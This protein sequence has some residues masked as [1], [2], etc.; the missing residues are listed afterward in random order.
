MKNTKN[1]KINVAKNTEVKGKVGRPALAVTLPAS[2]AFT[3][4]QLAE[5]NPTVK[6]ITLRGHVVRALEA[7]TVTKLDE[8]VKTGLKGKPAFKFMAT[9]AFASV[10]AKRDRRKA[11]KAKTA[12][13]EVPVTTPV[14]P[15]AELVGVG[16]EVE[17]V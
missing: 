2:G 1:T 6:P 4:K 3:L 11:A 5:L 12:K 17:S 16:T 10:K 13:V 15:N 7:G 14:E 9:K 8:T